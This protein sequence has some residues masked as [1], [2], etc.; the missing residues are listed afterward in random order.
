MSA[1]LLCVCVRVRAC[2]YVYERVFGVRVWGGKRFRKYGLYGYLTTHPWVPHNA[3]IEIS[4]IRCSF[5]SRPCCPV[6]CF[7]ISCD[8]CCFSLSNATTCVHD[9]RQER[10][11]ATTACSHYSLL[12]TS[13]GHACMSIQARTHAR[14]HT[15][16]GSP[17]GVHP[18]THM[19]AS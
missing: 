2:V 17:A 6:S 18:H 14:T 7:K 11:L 9:I 16:V 8:Q 1:H 3:F 4:K 13:T 5:C 15:N 10:V 12:K 19:H